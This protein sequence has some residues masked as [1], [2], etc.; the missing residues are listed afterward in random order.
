MSA[1]LAFDVPER[2]EAAEPP[3]ERGLA[4]D[5]VRL[6]VASRA[7]DDLVHARFRQLPQFL[8]PG[9][10]VV[11]NTSA[12]LPAAVPARRADGTELTLHLSTPMSNAQ[13]DRWVIELRR[14]D[15]RFYAG[16]QGETLTLQAGASAR[17]LAPYLSGKRLWVARLDLPESLQRY[18]AGHGRPIRY[19]YV[20]REQPLAAYQTVYATEPGS[21]E[22]PSAGR[23][24]SAEAITDLAARGVAVA[25]LVL[26]CGVSSLEDGEP[27]YPERFRVPVETARLVNATR[28][29][30]GRVIAV[31][32][33]VVRALETAARPDGTIEPAE[34]WTHLVVTAER[35]LRA[36]DGLVTGWHEP[37][38]S[39]LR[40]LEAVAGR[41]LVER[42]YRTALE[43][44]YL[45][46]EFG[47][48]HLILP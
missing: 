1:G 38:A 34:G 28:R 30:G 37:G 36:V 8:A 45:W 12:T 48:S 21:A 32:T 27:P 41:E 35:G 15:A 40:L 39:H 29:W 13:G 6:L 22:M 17:L 33:T 9:D 3:E 31:G 18:L 10:L 11:V 20:P 7:A 44:G 16:A 5:D 43:H 2:L 24:F 46:H 19:R 23:P 47:D 42:S 4:R 25:P 26:H 14:G